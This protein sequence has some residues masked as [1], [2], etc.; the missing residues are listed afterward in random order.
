MKKLSKTNK[1]YKIPLKR[2]FNHKTVKRRIQCQ[3]DFHY[4]VSL[5]K[6]KEYI[7]GNCVIMEPTSIILKKAPKPLSQTNGEKAFSF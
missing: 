4:L 3:V 7:R 6:F 5:K 1:A 2:P